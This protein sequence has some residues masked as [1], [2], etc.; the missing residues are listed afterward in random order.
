MTAKMMG[1]G[2]FALEDFLDQ[3]IAIRR[4]GPIANILGMMPG[5][6][7]MKEQL[8]AG[9]RQSF[10]SDHRDHPLDDPGRSAEEPKIINGPPGP[11]ARG[12][13]VTVMDVNQLLNRF[14][15]AQKMMKQMGR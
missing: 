3:L 14:T 15:E 7:E 13:G 6:G 2:S 8:A 11:I 1:G 5:M 12:S 4:M 9:R 10:R